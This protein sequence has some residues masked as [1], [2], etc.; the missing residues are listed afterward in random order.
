MTEDIKDTCKRCAYQKDRNKLLT[1][2]YVGWCSSQPHPC[3][4]CLRFPK[5]KMDYPDNFQE[6]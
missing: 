1:N 3:N 5:E 2:G 6:G 4:F